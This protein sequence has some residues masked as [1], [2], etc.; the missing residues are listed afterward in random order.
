M[1]TLSQLMQGFAV[2]MTPINLMWCLVGV[3]VGTAIGCCPALARR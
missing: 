1:D 2:A 3:A